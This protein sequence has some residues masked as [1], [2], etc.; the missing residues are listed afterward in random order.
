MLMVVIGC[1]HASPHRATRPLRRVP[2]TPWVNDEPY[3]RI[4]RG[5]PTDHARSDSM[6]DTTPVAV[7]PLR[8]IEIEHLAFH[9]VPLSAVAAMLSKMIGVNVIAVAPV[10]EKPISI[11]LSQVDARTAIEAICR[12]HDLWYRDGQGMIRLMSR[13]AYGN[14]I[15]VQSNEQTRFYYLKYASAQGVAE[16]IAS[17]MSD[18]VS[19][20]RPG[21]AGSFEHV[22]TDGDDPFE[23]RSSTSSS[24]TNQNNMYQQD[25]PPKTGGVSR[26]FYGYSASDVANSYRNGMEAQKVADAAESAEARRTGTVSAESIS[27]RSG[28]KYPVTLSVFTRNNC[29]GVRSVQASAHEQ[30]SGIIHALDTPTR[31]VLLEVKVLR[32]A[33]G[34][35]FESVFNLSYSFDVGNGRAN[36]SLLDKADI[37]GSTLSFSYLDHNVAAA[38]KLLKTDNRVHAVATPMLLCAN[39]APAEFFSGV[40]RMITVNYDFET[41][42]D[43]FNRAIDIARPIVQERGI[44]TTV[45]IKPSIN[46]DGTVTMRFLLDLSSVNENGA[47]IYEVAGDGEVIALPVD[48]VNNER[49]QSIVVARHGQA[50]VM[51]GLISETVAANHQRV[52]VAGDVPVLGTFFGKKVNSVS[53]IETIMIIIPHIMATGAINGRAVSER[54]LK[55][56]AVGENGKHQLAPITEWNQTSQRLQAVGNNHQHATTQPKNQPRNRTKDA[57]QP[58]GGVPHP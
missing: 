44:G 52:P 33:L 3:V 15:V 47:N 53:R 37:S 38:L 32:V 8:E 45:R 10:G 24:S 4:I 28:V 43:E 54:F 19:Y 50:V 2:D 11:E 57:G 34:D 25:V 12:T 36:L 22:G 40:T 21:G 29:I 6:K 20:I 48:T 7:D 49:A 31:Q 56:N 13:E 58:N 30:I 26:T 55:N 18:Q 1:R 41:R 27:K 9:R 16:M 17:L 35:D 5:N 23:N 39:N 14:E 42:Y 51:G 46:S